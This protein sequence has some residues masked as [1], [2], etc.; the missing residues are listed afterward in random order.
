MTITIVLGRNFNKVPTDDLALTKQ[1]IAFSGD[2]G[3]D[4]I[5]ID[6]YGGVT[7][8]LSASYSVPVELFELPKP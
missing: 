3:T 7:S 2:I 1:D 8:K 5:Y 6:T 4:K